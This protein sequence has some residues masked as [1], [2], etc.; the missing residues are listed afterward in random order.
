MPP[1]GLSGFSRKLKGFQSAKKLQVNIFTYLRLCFSK[2]CKKS[3]IAKKIHFFPIF[4][5][6][7]LLYHIVLLQQ[8]TKKQLVW[9]RDFLSSQISQEFNFKSCRS[10]LSTTPISISINIDYVFSLLQKKCSEVTPQTFL[11]QQYT[12]IIVHSISQTGNNPKPN[13]Y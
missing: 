11:K 10:G 7:S 2:F 4:P 8:K 5:L 13:Y 12:V 9:K 3:K 6:Q 1:R